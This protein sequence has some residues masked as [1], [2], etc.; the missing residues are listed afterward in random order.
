MAASATK[1]LPHKELWVGQKRAHVPLAQMSAAISQATYSR[2]FNV[3]PASIRPGLIRLLL[4]LGPVISRVA[5]C[6][7]GEFLDTCRIEEGSV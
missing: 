4:R 3:D 7:C 5:L 1:K 2:I 6:C